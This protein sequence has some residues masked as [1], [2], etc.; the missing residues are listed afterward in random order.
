MLLDLE[1]DLPTFFTTFKFLQ[2]DKKRTD[3][4]IILMLTRTGNRTHD[5]RYISQFSITNVF[6]F[7]FFFVNRKKS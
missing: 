5:S 3:L 2:S 4:Y 7:F 6:F 1:T